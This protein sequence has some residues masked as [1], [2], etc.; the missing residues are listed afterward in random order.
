MREG[1][2]KSDVLAGII[3]DDTALRLNQHLGAQAW[4]AAQPLAK[5]ALAGAIAA[6]NIGMIKKID[7]EFEGSLEMQIQLRT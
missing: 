6:V 7:A 2:V 4:V 3:L 1:E 5:M